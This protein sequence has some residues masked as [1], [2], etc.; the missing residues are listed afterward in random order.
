MKGEIS[1]MVIG[2][3]AGAIAVLIDVLKG[4]PAD[5]PIPLLAVI[6][7]SRTEAG[8][9]S[10]LIQK[11][12]SLAVRDAI[13]AMML[14]PG[15]LTLAPSNRHLEVTMGGSLELSAGDSVH[16]SRPSIDV[17]FKSA[18]KAFSTQVVALVLSGSNDDGVAGADA[19]K[20]AGGQ[21]VVQ[22]PGST[23]FGF[24]PE[25]V[26]QQVETDILL[27]P[28]EISMFLRKLQYPYQSMP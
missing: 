6:H 17:L 27:D 11:T 4:L 25:K 22:H 20:Q 18:A 10:Q 1:L 23:R 5:Y 2:G 7:R 8:E 24:L 12:V 28:L 21:V 15:T 9:L 14:E 26:L 16:G 3:S 19:I 13:E